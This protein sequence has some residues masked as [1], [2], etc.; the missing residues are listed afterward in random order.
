[1]LMES[2]YITAMITFRW[3][4]AL[5]PPW[6]KILNLTYKNLTYK[7][8][9]QHEPSVQI[10]K[11]LICLSFSQKVVERSLNAFML[12]ICMLKIQC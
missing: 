3:M 2:I 9:S 10:S 7:K 5:W 6:H 8:T 11:L 12:Q 1:M 4:A